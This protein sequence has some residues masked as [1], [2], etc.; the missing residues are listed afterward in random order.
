MSYPEDPHL[1]LVGKAHWAWSRLEWRMINLATAEKDPT[2]RSAALA[3]IATKTGW[4]IVQDLLAS[5]TVPQDLRDSLEALVPRRNTLAHARPATT[6][7]GFQRLYRW[8][9]ERQGVSAEFL[10]DDWLISFTT[11]C[12]QASRKLQE[13]S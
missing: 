13:C 1:V 4:P 10:T 11:D 7:D 8:D 9:P 5:I 6:P 3:L 2:K 12:E